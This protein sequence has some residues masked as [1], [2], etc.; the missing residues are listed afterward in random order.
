M[1]H[2][3]NYNTKKDTTV[4]EYLNN[5][6]KHIANIELADRIKHEIA[7]FF[8]KDNEKNYIKYFSEQ[9]AD[10]LRNSNFGKKNVAIIDKLSEELD[11]SP[12]TFYHMLNGK[13]SQFSKIVEVLN[14]FNLTFRYNVFLQD[15]RIID[16]KKDLF[17]KEEVEKVTPLEEDIF[18]LVLESDV[19]TQELIKTMLLRFKTNLEDPEKKSK[20]I[21]RY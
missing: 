16:D 1:Q 4:T 6:Q 21:I 14:F 17:L 9:E 7:V 2:T 13:N 15:S 8:E 5:A 18:K 19:E 3:N 12:K 11:M 10:K 20:T